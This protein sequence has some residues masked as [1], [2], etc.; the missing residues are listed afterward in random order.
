MSIL[1][2]NL[3]LLRGQKKFS[4]Q[5]LAEELIIT[6]VRLA[7][8]ED[9]RTEPPIDILKRIAN[10]FHISID[11]LI[12]VQLNKTSLEK[13]SELGDNRILLPITV[14]K[15]GK[16]NVEV[17]PIKAKAG[18]LTG[19]ADPEYIEGLQQMR[20]PFLGPGKHRAFPISGDSMPPLT[21]GTFIIGRFVE[22]LKEIKDGKT[23]IIISRDQGIVYKRVY[24]KSEKSDVL[25]LH[26]DNKQYRA[27][28]I[29]PKDILEV[30]SY[31]ASFSTKET[32][33]DEI[34]YESVR[35][36]FDQL[37][38]DINSLRRDLGKG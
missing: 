31:T 3:R 14:D 17:V 30:W 35:E 12:S 16:D 24:R 20:I 8:Y 11:V 15:D 5:R 34:H 37:R 18:Y 13:L 7:A 22:R 27:Y 19:F 38:I 36:M 21:E 4:Q 1:S 23:Y 10:Y 9:A 28:D 6:R 2:E 29:K 25:T 32:L 33:P 26:S